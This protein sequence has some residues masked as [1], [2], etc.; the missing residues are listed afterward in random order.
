[1]LRLFIY[2]HVSEGSVTNI[3]LG[4]KYLLFLWKLLHVC[5]FFAYSMLRGFINLFVASCTAALLSV[6]KQLCFQSK[7]EN[8]PRESDPFDLKQ[9][10]KA[11]V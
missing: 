1:M 8:R 5:I 10:L 4:Q 11:S 9:I 3:C 7:H 6:H 2:V